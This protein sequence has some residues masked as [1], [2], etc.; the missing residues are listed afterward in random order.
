MGKRKCF[1]RT[2]IRFAEKTS[3]V[4][5]PYINSTKFW[6]AKL[7]WSS[8]YLVAIAAKILHLW[9]LFDQFYPGPS[10]RTWS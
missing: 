4:G 8:L 7:I 3:M 10:R 2:I 1:R 6:W 5:V 9:Y